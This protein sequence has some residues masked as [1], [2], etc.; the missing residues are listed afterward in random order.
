MDI[1][2]AIEIIEALASGCSP[3][4]G[5]KLNESVLNERDVIR[6]LQIVIDQ[7]KQKND[8]LQ[9]H[10]SVRIDKEDIDEAIRLFQE[11]NM[12]PTSSRLS[13][14]FLGTRSFTDDFINTNKLYG[15][16]KG[17]YQKGQL[18]DFFAFYLLD[19]G[20]SKHG[21]NIKE[22]NKPWEEI[23]YFQKE[24]FN[25]LSD[26]AINRLKEKIN[27]LG[28]V[29]TEGLSEEVRKARINYPRAYEA[30]TDEEKDILWEALQ[31][32]NDLDLLSSCFQRG[33]NSIRSM[34]MRVIY[35]KQ[36][37][38]MTDS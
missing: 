38:K 26:E 34:G 19:K 14:F 27:K 29:K 3:I 24:P 15:K 10:T 7:L 20:Y 35:E 2:K 16:Y 17:L 5:E 37:L 22:K 13:S 8:Y 18:L 11:Y 25:N 21:K 9:T 1:N 32:T 12:A 30:W 23:D 28:V 31:G 36:K 33:E 4:T 6:A